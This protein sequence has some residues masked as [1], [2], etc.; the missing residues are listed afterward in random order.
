MTPGKTGMAVIAIPEGKPLTRIPLPA[1][2]QGIAVEQEG[3]RIYANLP[4][5]SHIEV[6]SRAEGKSIAKWGLDGARDNFPMAL[7]E[8][9]HRLFVACRKP[10]EML[11]LDTR[12]GNVVARVP[13]VGEADDMS[14]DPAHK[15]LYI[16][17]AEGSVSVTE[18]QDADHYRLLGSVTTGPDA[19][20]S[21]FSTQLN[22]LYVGVPRRD[23]KPAE[24]LSFTSAR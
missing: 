1:S 18:Q 20:N 11:V 13:C 14:Y 3:T 9:D 2:P 16:S 24:I 12:S 22:S 23:G 15:R 8:L 10:P 7:D 19:A 5:A 4:T 21:V 17:G 6:V